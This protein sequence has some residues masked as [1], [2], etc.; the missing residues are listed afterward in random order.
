MKK[1][2]I[3]CDE[4]IPYAREAFSRVGRVCLLPAEEIINRNIR[5]ADVLVIRSVTKV[6]PELLS[7]TSV[8]IVGSVT[9]GID[10]IDAAYLNKGGIKLIS[11]PGSNANSVSEYVIA[12]L[13]VLSE[14]K[15]IT[16]EG[17]K[18]GIVGVGHVGSRVD[19]KCRALGMKTVWNDPPLARPDRDIK[20]R[21]M[22]EI[23]SCDIVTLHMPLTFRG[24]DATY[25]L[26]GDELLRGMKDPFIF[27]NTA[28]G[29][30]VDEKAILEYGRKGLFQGMVIDV[31]P[32]EPDID[33]GLLRMADIATPHVAGYSIDGKVKAVDMVY[34]DLCRHYKVRD[35]WSVTAM[36]RPPPD[37]L[38]K[39]PE[40]KGGGKDTIKK[41]VLAAYD[42]RVDDR[43]LRR[44]ALIDP[45]KRGEYFESLRQRY[46]VR[47]EFGN[48]RVS[49]AGVSLK[50]KKVLKR[51][52]FGC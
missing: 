52:G 39:V 49:L 25:H 14:M 12:A 48:Y 33:R 47:R 21:S 3:V 6:A 40:A 8:E 11:A 22:R 10:H 44:I 35:N 50:H 2:I 17:K 4:Q 29:K 19:K 9:S 32:D 38:I 36:L 31:W 5:A 51:L 30:V 46:P 43:N 1:P 24:R 28:R 42:P 34:K 13:L 27:I 16:L 7:G 20:Y 18:V 23:C 41:A 37:P 45:K 26:V 15:G